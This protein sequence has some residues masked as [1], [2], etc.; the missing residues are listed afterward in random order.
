MKTLWDTKKLEFFEFFKLLF[1]IFEKNNTK[2]EY[3][4]LLFL[5][6]FFQKFKRMA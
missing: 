1:S 3:L 4:L 2:I 6:L 5:G